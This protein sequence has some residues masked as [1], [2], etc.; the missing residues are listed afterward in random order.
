MVTHAA[1]LQHGGMDDDVM[2]E[3]R[4]RFILAAKRR[5]AILHNEMLLSEVATQVGSQRAALYVCNCAFASACLTPNIWNP[6]PH[7]PTPPH[8]HTP[9]TPHPHTLH[10]AAS[11]QFLLFILNAGLASSH[12]PLSVWQNAASFFPSASV[13][14]GPSRAIWG[15]R[16][17]EAEWVYFVSQVAYGTMAAHEDGRRAMR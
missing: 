4:F 17:L 8:P 3:K 9:S 1:S 14:Q 13:V 7:T 6:H 10:P 16:W 15:W 5:V 11:F 12:K 2:K